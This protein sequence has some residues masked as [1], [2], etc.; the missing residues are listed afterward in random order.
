LT[1]IDGETKDGALGMQIGYARNFGP[2]SVVTDIGFYIGILNRGSPDHDWESPAIGTQAFL[3][4]KLRLGNFFVHSMAGM[5]YMRIAGE[6]AYTTNT[7]GGPRI[8]YWA[9]YGGIEGAWADYL[10]Q[11]GEQEEETYYPGF[12]PFEMLASALNLGLGMDI[13]SLRIVF[14]YLPVFEKELRNDF[15]LSFYYVFE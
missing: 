2:A 6:D 15:R 7:G 1:G 5:V 11:M 3:G 14:E 4:P 13:L 9:P 8:T 10:N 12:P